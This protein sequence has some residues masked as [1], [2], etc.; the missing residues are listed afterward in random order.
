M[1]LIDLPTDLRVEAIHMLRAIRYSGPFCHSMLGK[2]FLS[3]H[4]EQVSE[5]GLF[6]VTIEDGYTIS[7]QGRPSTRHV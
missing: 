4:I 7:E 2:E 1:T 5:T 6:E 3:H